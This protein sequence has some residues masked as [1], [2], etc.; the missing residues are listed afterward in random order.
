MVLIALR[1][2]SIIPNFLQIFLKQSQ[3]SD[4][5]H[6]VSVLNGTRF[7][8]YQ[9]GAEVYHVGSLNWWIRIKLWARSTHGWSSW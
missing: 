1:D 9:I 4:I 5:S 7:T 2:K 3:S 8:S 6:S